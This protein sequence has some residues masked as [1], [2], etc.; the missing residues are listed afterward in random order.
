MT[1]CIYGEET[2]AE[3]SMTQDAALEEEFQAL[4]AEQAASRKV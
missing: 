3:I 2:P 1:L 4:Q